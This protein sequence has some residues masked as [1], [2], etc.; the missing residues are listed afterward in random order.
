MVCIQLPSLSPPSPQAQRQLKSRVRPLI[1]C[2]SEYISLLE[3][4]F[5][6]KLCT[7]EYVDN[8][9]QLNLRVLHS[10]Y[11]L[12]PCAREYVDKTCHSLLC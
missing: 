12:K 10:V 8:S 7:C 2:Y 5:M 3:S 9:C 4:V 1:V 6:L 11:I